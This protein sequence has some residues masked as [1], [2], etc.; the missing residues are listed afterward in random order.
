MP[1]TDKQVCIP[2]ELPDLLKQFTK[3]AIRTQPPDLILW[4]SEYFSA[5]ARGE[6]PPVRE[7]ADRVPLSNWAELTPE[8][9]KVLHQ[10]VGG[11]LIVHVDELAQMWK[12]LNLPTDLFDSVMNV[13][14]FTEEIEW[15]KFL[16]LACSSLGVTIA[17]TLKIICEV[18]SNENDSGPARIPFSTFQFL[19]TYIAEVDGEISASHVS[20]MLNYIE[21]EIIG[22]DGL[23]K[24][25]DFTQN[26][27]VRLE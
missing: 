18:L 22:P 23:I 26:P 16:A 9:L 15:L 4:S 7:R 19:Y 27:R 20:R 12:V 14:R 21:Q 3:A 11:R 2:P 24:V 10:R 8:L 6:L 25:T 1:Q 5:M 17:K 13:G